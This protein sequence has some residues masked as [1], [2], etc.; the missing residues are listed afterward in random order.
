MHR[1]PK[2]LRGKGTRVR[3]T[4]EEPTAHEKERK[5]TH[6][7]RECTSCRQQPLPS[8]Q[9]HTHAS[10]LCQSSARA[11]FVVRCAENTKDRERR[12]AMRN[13]GSE[14]VKA[15]T[16][17]TASTHHPSSLSPPSVSAPLPPSPYTITTA[18][19]CNAVSASAL[20]VYTQHCTKEV[21]GWAHETNPLRPTSPPKWHI[22]RCAGTFVHISTLP[23]HHLPA[24]NQFSASSRRAR[25]SIVGASHIMCVCST[26]Q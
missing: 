20:P 5:H 10:L 4:G 8:P 18:M 25:P 19:C 12:G 6:T 16:P 21:E 11:R 7:E 14:L 13:D 3:I 24:S 15:S 23:H 26:S 9:A 2:S 22:Q 17:V 1:R